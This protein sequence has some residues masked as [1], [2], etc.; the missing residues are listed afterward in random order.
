MMPTKFEQKL[1]VKL[2]N[3]LYVNGL[4]K[5]RLITRDKHTTPPPLLAGMSEGGV[6]FFVN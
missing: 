2:Y 6:D 5:V 3:C 1:G 4:F